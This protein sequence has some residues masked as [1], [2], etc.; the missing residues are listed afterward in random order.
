M[1]NIFCSN[2]CMLN[3]LIFLLIFCCRFKFI[4]EMINEIY[5]IEYMDFND[6]KNVSFFCFLV[7]GLD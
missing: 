7:L 3:I 6:L 4:N 1:G 2:I 5:E